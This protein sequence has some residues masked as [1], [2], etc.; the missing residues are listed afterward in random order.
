[1]QQAREG[2]QTGFQS[3]T[4][5]NS[6]AFILQ[7]WNALVPTSLFDQSVN[8]VWYLDWNLP[9]PFVS[10][11][12]EG[13]WGRWNQLRLVNHW[14]IQ[15]LSPG[16]LPQLHVCWHFLSKSEGSWVP[17]HV[18][19]AAAWEVEEVE[20]ESKVLLGCTMNSRLA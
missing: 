7:L 4:S 5:C 20:R 2:Q 8:V 19:N 18:C 13:Q 6:L 1:M 10:E 12:T 14:G 3:L 9:T 17:P 11:E 16:S 15:V